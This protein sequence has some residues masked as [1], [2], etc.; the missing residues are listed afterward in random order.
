MI[1]P[2]NKTL[3]FQF[4]EIQRHGEIAVLLVND[5]PANT[6]TYDLVAQLDE[7]FF[8]LSL[9]GSTRAV[10]ITGA[11]QRFFSGGVN[12]GMLCN[13]SLHYNSN[14]LL[15]ASEVFERIDKSP[16]LV[17]AAINGHATGGGLE[18][19]LVAD[20]RLAVEGTYNIGFPEVR[21]GVIP[22]LGGTQRLS[23]IVGRRLA[24]ELIT[25]GDFLSLPQAQK[26]GIVD[27][28]LPGK[29]FVE[30]AIDYARK[31]LQDGRS[32][33][34]S[35]HFVPSWPKPDQAL[36]NYSRQGRVGVITLA[37]NSGELPSLQVLRE[38]QHAIFTAR[39][40]QEA[41]VLMLT[42]KGPHLRLGSDSYDSNHVWR[43]AQLV[44]ES[45]ENTPR[46]CVLGFCGSLDQLGSE[47]ALACD[48]RLMPKDNV[49]EGDIFSFLPT[50]PRRM[51]YQLEESGCESNDISMTS[52]QAVE[53]GLVRLVDGDS[54]PQAVQVWLG[55]FVSPRG[56]SKSV[57]YAKL[58]IV[59]GSLLPYEAGML[60]ER[61]LQEQLFRGHDGPEGMRAY[62][63]KRAPVFKGI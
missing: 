31:R 40:D 55:R 53:Q 26:L 14:F 32:Q 50:S 49:P 7:V 9:E 61:H 63:E 51:A 38:L 11:G 24:L 42:H 48:Y 13:V 52:T 2:Q 45:L 47:L 41:E 33:Y 18:L 5:P 3:I 35:E 62:L 16:L 25:Q 17:V 1:R 37:E 59:R 46:L 56:A 19:A 27:A 54:W 43:Q 10:V 34:S 15:F 22:G 39:L 30:G 28:V 36:V 44:F 12:I 6:L 20:I 60:V 8:E 29:N 57:G 23:R 58:A 4:I 21:L